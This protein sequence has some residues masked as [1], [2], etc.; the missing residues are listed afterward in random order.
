MSVVICL[1]NSSIKL[2]DTHVYIINELP[3]FVFSAF[4][5]KSDTNVEDFYIDINLVLNLLVTSL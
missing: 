5:L 3:I 2:M 1:N 4:Y